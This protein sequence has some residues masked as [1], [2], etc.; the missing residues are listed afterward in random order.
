MID[1]PIE[2]IFKLHP[3]QKVGLNKLNLKTIRDLLYYFPIRYSHIS[4]I[5]TISDTESEKYVTIHGIIRS[6]QSKRSFTTK[7]LQS[8]AIVEDIHGDTI[9]IV[10]FNQHYISKM[11][12]EGSYVRLTGKITQA[13]NKKALINPEIEKIAVLPID[14]HESLFVRDGQEEVSFGFPIYKETKGVTSKWIY[15]AIK[16]IIKENIHEEEK[17]IL[18]DNILKKYGLP[19]ISSALV[20]IHIPRTENDA[21]AAKKRF[22]FQEIY[23]IQIERQYEK[24]ILSKE[25]AYSINPQEEDVKKFIE[26]F[27]FQPTKGQAE[28]IKIILKD[29]LKDSPMSRLLEG[30]VG[31]GK[32]FIAATASFATIKTRP[33]NQNFGTLQVAYM[34]PTEILATQ[35]FENFTEYFKRTG[36]AIGLLTGS[37]CKKFP[38]KIQQKNGSPTWTNISRSQL[39]KWVA[40]GEIN[41]IIG[42]HALIQKSISFKH[43]ALV[44]IDEQHRFGKNQRKALAKKDGFL[45]HLLSM[46]ATPIPR[47]L[48]LTLYGDL[49]LSILS[50]LPIGRK[51]VITQVVY[52]E[53]REEVY[54]K[55]KIEVAQGRQVYIICPRIDD[56]DPNKEKSLQ[57]KSVTEEAKRLKKEVFTKESIDILHSKMTKEKKEAVMNNFYE[58]KI[59]ILVATSVIEVGVNVPNATTII[60]EGAE[61]FGLS[62]LHQ[63]RGRVQRSSHQSY[64]Y[65]FADSKTEKTK[66]RLEYF[67]KA[68]DGFELAEYDLKLR[69][70]GE[71]TGDK[72]W[73]LNDI[74]MEAIRNQKLVEA[75]RTEALEY[76]KNDTPLLKGYHFE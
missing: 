76:I 10:W 35:H 74:A 17:E 44:I 28:A 54:Q 37:G 40:N 2:K 31:S 34:V 47:T 36:I 41:I 61:R 49:D 9:E 18:A 53:K 46:S 12:S 15:H 58:G 1:S 59:D 3:L 27:N 66:E 67:L 21:T 11:Y 62:Q 25:K 69:G 32:T 20:W 63:L 57:I 26:S 24:K 39:V 30:D 75:A 22:A 23:L 72:Q 19:K 38:S 43:L 48:A 56:A 71:L 13:K 33:K 50:D 7:K 45:P 16:K 65:I 29:L 6:I 68:K 51:K 8:Y 73:G 42:T 55:I 4:E 14:T 60:I 70:T 52:P 5:T 64:C